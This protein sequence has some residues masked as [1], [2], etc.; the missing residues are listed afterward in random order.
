MP[1]STNWGSCS[2]AYTRSVVDK[3]GSVESHQLDGLIIEYA[4]RKSGFIRADLRP[5]RLWL[6]FKTFFNYI[7]LHGAP[8]YYNKG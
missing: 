3:V 6:A 1:N 5:M 4:T 7:D 2:T 8:Q